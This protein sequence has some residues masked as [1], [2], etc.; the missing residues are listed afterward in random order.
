MLHIYD[1]SR[2]HFGSVI[3]HLTLSSRGSTIQLPY[4][5]NIRVTLKERYNARGHKL[6]IPTR[7]KAQFV[8]VTGIA[9]VL[10]CLYQGES[11]WKSQN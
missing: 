2:I 5:S 7:K 1:N 10:Y 4:K 8:T 11:K 3:F 6:R 9:D